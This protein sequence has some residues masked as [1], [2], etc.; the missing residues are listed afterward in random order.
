MK[1]QTIMII[2]AGKGQLPAIL[3]AKEMGLHVIA[4]DKSPAAP[5]MKFA[6]IALP[7]DF[8][9]IP[10]VIKEAYKHKINAAMTMQGDL[11]VITVGKIVDEFG[12]PGI[13]YET[14]MRCIN[15]LLMSE[16][17]LKKGI[18]TPAALRVLTLESAE[19]AVKEIG[20]PCIIKAADSSG[21]RGVTKIL[22]EKQIGPAFKEALHYSNIGQVCVQ[23]FINGVE[24][25]A[26]AFSVD[27][28][29]EIVLVHNDAMS[30]P[31]YFIPVMHS[32]PSKL[33]P[34]QLKRVE[35]AV[36]DSVEA[37][38]I[39]TGPSNIDII[40][41]EEGEP[42]IIEIGARIGATCL[43]ELVHHFSGINWV[44]AAIE[45]ALGQK[46]DLTI[47]K[48]MPCAAGI[49]EAPGDGILAGYDIPKDVYS[50]GGVFEIEIETDIGGKISKLR[51]GT[52]RMGRI[53]VGDKDSDKAEAKIEWIKS[54]I[55]I[56][57]NQ[58][59]FK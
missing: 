34:L 4:V 31:P 9:D 7:I 33:S 55:S 18:K 56:E 10:S 32:F 21:S 11:P 37:L 5:G 25:G 13:D 43:P 58:G 41:S 14:A 12:L 1:Q 16:C 22:E 52:D 51:N 27:G 19:K 59:K 20:M 36:T 42:E 28:R 50:V 3:L 49:I 23:K 15:K 45:A 24:M 35:K 2:G 29:C 54:R 39:H 47:K 17:L 38:G 6:D 46:P 40:L 26:Q 57:I 53:V 48:C 30:D 44:R 8:I